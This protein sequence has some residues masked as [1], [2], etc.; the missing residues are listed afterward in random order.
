[1]SG[2]R[3]P[4]YHRA[5]GDTTTFS[6]H[7]W[8]AAADVFIDA[9]GDGKM[10]DLDGNGVIDQRD[11]ALL[12]ALADAMDREPVEDWT[13][14]RRERVPRDRLARPVRPRRRARPRRALVALSARAHPAPPTG[15]TRPPP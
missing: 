8:G 11:A 4:A 5:I 7:L 6:R 2:Y 14:G 9:D 12:F 15:A 3:T 13:V 10:D 1:M